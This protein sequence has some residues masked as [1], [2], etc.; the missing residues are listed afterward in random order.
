MFD[1]TPTPAHRANLNKAS[2]EL[3]V[4]TKMEEEFWRQKATIRWASDGKR[5]SKFFH[6]WVKQKRVKSRIRSIEAGGQIL[7]EETTI[8]DSVATFF[9][10]LL[11]SDFG[12]LE[13]PDLTLIHSLPESVDQE[14]LCLAPQEKEVRETVFEISGDSVS[15]L[16]GF[17]SL[18]FQN[19][20]HCRGRCDCSSWELFQ[21]GFH[22]SKLHINHD[23]SH[24]EEARSSHVGGL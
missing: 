7:T 11:T 14:T 4:V 8:R 10:Q 15:G 6:G 20:W 21:R 18:F 17:T 5:N 16:N 23:Y 9:Q 12:V 3:I 22:T 13:Q 24:T 19:C 1:N 2:T